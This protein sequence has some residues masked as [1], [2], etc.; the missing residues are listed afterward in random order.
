MCC[1]F[2]LLDGTTFQHLGPGKVAK[3]CPIIGGFAP[4]YHLLGPCKDAPVLRCLCGTVVGDGDGEAD[5]GW[6]LTGV[7]LFFSDCA[8]SAE[9]LRLWYGLGDGLLVRVAFR[10]MGLDECVPLTARAAEN[11]GFHIICG[12]RT[13]DRRSR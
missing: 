4:I 2:G 7:V 5:W 13:R 6:V 3:E 11:R 12:T 1:G 8:R 9:G 10:L